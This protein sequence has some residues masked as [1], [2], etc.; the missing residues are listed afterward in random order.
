MNELEVTVNLKEV[1]KRFKAM[2]NSTTSKI[3][4]IIKN[5]A[6][7]LGLVKMYDLFVSL[8]V[9]MV[10]CSYANEF[11]CHLKDREE[12]KKFSWIWTPD[13]KYKEVKNIVLACKNKPQLMFCIQNNI[14]YFVCFD[15]AMHRGGF[16]I[17][18]IPELKNI[19]ID[20]K[21][22]VMTH[23]PHET[24]DGAYDYSN[25]VKN[26]IEELKNSGFTIGKVTAANS[27]IF[28]NEPNCHYDYCRVGEALLLPKVKDK[29]SPDGY[30][31]ITI[32]T[33][34]ADSMNLNAGD[35]VGYDAEKLLN[36]HKVA[37]LPIGYYSFEVEH[38]NYVLI[39]DGEN[40]IKCKVITSMHD[41]TII[42]VDEVKEINNNEV[43]I[44][45]KDLINDN[46]NRCIQKT[47][48]LNP[49]L[50]HYNYI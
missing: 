17:N 16:T 24:V 12:I 38:L 40:W 27:Y 29:F 8:G 34:I 10:A 15:I 13:E 9:K 31:S 25:K 28:M 32:K 3:V 4:P 23:C 21:I 20:N 22:N 41:T 6:N 43:I 1:E 45:N 14:P 50:V 18:D 39:K 2:Q 19:I 7:G 26:L 11:Y 49:D 48:K 37:V 46:W 30:D 42:I 5:N 35:Y 44:M 36:N 33:Y 47:F